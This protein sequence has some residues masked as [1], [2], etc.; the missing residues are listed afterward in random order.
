[1]NAPGTL[2]A[3]AIV[4]VTTAPAAAQQA[5]PAATPASAAAKSSLPDFS[6]VW[7]HGSLP[8]FVPPASGPGP[9]TNKARRKDNGQSDYGML[10]GDYANPILQPWA[11]DVVKKK[12]ELSLSGVTYPSPANQCWP[13]PVPFLF[14]HM[15]MQVIQLPDKIVMLFNEDHEVRWVALDK[16]HPAKVTPSWHGDAVAHYEGDTLVIDT[17]GVKVDRPFAMIDLFGTPYTDKLH[18]VERYR[19]LD[20]DEVKGDIERAAKEN[21]RPA[22]PMNQSYND[23]YLQVHFTVEDEGAFTMP[24]TATVIYL[25]DRGEWPEIACA[26]NPAGFHHDKD[27]DIPYAAKP[28]F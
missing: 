18:V 23:K 24:W 20:R 27:A 10:V 12:G 1:M 25:R 22:G 9:V 26:E 15:A 13:E 14:K 5:T 17:V 4:A 19:L 21:W 16:P 8:W 28:D 2:L 11:A 3:L 6:G 7:R